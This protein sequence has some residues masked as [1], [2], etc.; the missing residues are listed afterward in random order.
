MLFLMFRQ[1]T[2]RFTLA[3]SAGNITIDAQGNDTDIMLKDGGSADTTFLTLDG[4]VFGV[5][6]DD[7][8]ANVQL[9]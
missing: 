1:V 4:S 9:L 3:T 2:F 6:N 7:I 5:F 8:T